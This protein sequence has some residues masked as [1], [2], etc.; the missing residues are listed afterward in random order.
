MNETKPKQFAI[1]IQS[2]RE[3]F[4]QVKANR[5]A[6]GVDGESITKFEEHLDNNLYK[7]WNRMSS[8]TYFPPAVKAVPIPKKS[9]GTRVLGIPTVTDRVAQATVKM[10]LEPE[11]EPLFYEDSY[12]Y[13]PGK[14]QHQAIEVTRARCWR[15]KWVLEF[16]IVGLF[17]NI[18][19]EL[20]MAMV[21]R[22]AKQPWVVLYI[23]RWRKAPFDDRGAITPRTAGTPQGGVISPLLANLF[24]HYVFD[25]Y[26]ASEFSTLPWARYADD[27]IVHCVSKKQALFLL[28][29]LKAR[30]ER[31]KLRL[32]PDKTRI[33]YCGDDKETRKQELTSFDFLGFTFRPRG[34][35]NSKTGKLFTGFLPAVSNKSKKTMLQKMTGW[36]LQREIALEIEDIA[37]KINP[38]IRGWM[39]YY[40]KFYPSEVKR[41]FLHVNMWLCK[42]VKRKYKKRNTWKKAWEWLAQL[43]ERK[44][45][46]FYHWELGVVPSAG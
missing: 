18:D 12:G 1:L 45:K 32:H 19:H 28:S 24:L 3:A 14:S 38:Q 35:V 23:K 40:G 27:G 25:S 9:G 31:F 13:R 6:A 5:G 17:D 15:Y 22:H 29:K 43:C 26:M 42:Y 20:L 36:K 33:I 44:P 7:L 10:Y 4:E 11:V 34:A 30:F 2:V 37:D 16:D 21:T 39:N 8:G 41:L 46:L